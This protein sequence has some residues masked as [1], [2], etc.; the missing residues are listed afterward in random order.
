VN[1]LVFTTFPGPISA[2]RVNRTIVYEKS[3][4]NV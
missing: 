3:Y 1:I 4:N 2:T